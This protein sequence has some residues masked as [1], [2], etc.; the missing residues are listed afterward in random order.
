[1]PDDA[2]EH[3]AHEGAAADLDR[4]RAH[5]TSSKVMRTSVSSSGP[6]PQLEGL[7]QRGDERQPEPEARAV[8]ARE[9]AAALVADDHGQRGLVDASRARRAARRRVRVGV[10][11]DV[12]ARLGDRELDVRQRLVGDVHDVAQAAEGVPD[13]RDVLRA[14]GQGQD[15]IWLGLLQ[16]GRPVACPAFG[17]D[18]GSVARPLGAL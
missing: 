17:T 12:R 4:G 3:G 2:A 1:M 6:G 9:D 5:Q 15:Q 8:G 16:C 14:R 11:D 10:D 7:G 13:H 18:H